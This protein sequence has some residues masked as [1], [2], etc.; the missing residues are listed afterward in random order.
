M[1]ANKA[2]YNYIICKDNFDV[3]FPNE[4][5]TIDN[6]LQEYKIKPTQPKILTYGKDW[7][8]VKEDFKEFYSEN[9]LK[10]HYSNNLHCEKYCSFQVLVLYNKQWNI[11]GFAARTI[12]PNEKEI[13]FL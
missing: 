8:K 2:E 11:R 4:T 12:N 10:N 6:I 13:L 7:D 9:E 1:I 5:Y 3:Y